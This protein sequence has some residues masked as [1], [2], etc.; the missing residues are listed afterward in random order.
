MTPRPAVLDPVPAEEH[1]DFE[2]HVQDELGYLREGLGDLRKQVGGLTKQ[3][4]GLTKQVGGLDLKVDKM[5]EQ[6]VDLKDDQSQILDRLDSIEE[7][8]KS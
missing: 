4:G 7:Y 6:L 2:A 1:A 8:L 3:V 5:S